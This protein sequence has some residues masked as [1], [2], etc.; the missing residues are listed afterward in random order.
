MILTAQQ[1][2]LAQRIIAYAAVI[3]G[4][5]TQALAGIHLPW[6]ASLILGVFGTLLHPDTSITIP[7]TPTTAAVA[8]APAG[9]TFVQTAPGVF[10]PA[11][12][13]HSNP[14]TVTP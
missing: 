13:T 1:K 3:M 9:T 8:A 7:T 4:V 2:A 14:G 10:T 12:V 6:V 11:D 5:L